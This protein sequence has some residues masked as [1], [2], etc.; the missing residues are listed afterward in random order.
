MAKRIWE[1]RDDGDGVLLLDAWDV[2]EYGVRPATLPLVERGARAGGVQV[3]TSLA[4]P[5]GRVVAVMTQAAV[6]SLK[7]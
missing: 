7:V 6:D 5:V 4:V 2:G 1:A 3:M